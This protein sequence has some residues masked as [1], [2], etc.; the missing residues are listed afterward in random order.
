LLIANAKV[1]ADLADNF[2]KTA[3][4]LLGGAAVLIGTGFAYLQF[5]EQQRTLAGVG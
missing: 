5:T 1:R 4:Q 3:G 2:R